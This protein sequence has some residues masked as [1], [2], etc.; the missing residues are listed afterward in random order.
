VSHPSDFLFPSDAVV[1][2]SELYDPEKSEPIVFKDND[3]DFLVV[4]PA[5]RKG[6]FYFGIV[7]GYPFP[8]Q[9]IHGPAVARQKRI[10]ERIRSI[11]PSINADDCYLE[12]SNPGAPL[13]KAPSLDHFIDLVNS[14]TIL[15]SGQE[16]C[17][18]EEWKEGGE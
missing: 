4:A 14:P 8:Q 18:G 11:N 17:E 9:F 1:Y 5:P 13:S 10:W 7:R 12:F 3:E 2:L 16:H 15:R 6:C